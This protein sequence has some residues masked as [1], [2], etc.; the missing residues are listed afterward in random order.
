LAMAFLAMAIRCTKVRS[1][2]GKSEVSLISIKEGVPMKS[3]P[4]RGKN[5]PIR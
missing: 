4:V 1:R 2:V 3:P 5:P